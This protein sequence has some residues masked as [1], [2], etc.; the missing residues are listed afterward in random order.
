MHQEVGSEAL[1]VTGQSEGPGSLGQAPGNGDF[2][3]L[4][5][6]PS[7]GTPDHKAHTLAR[8]RAR[9]RG[10]P[11]R[12]LLAVPGLAQPFPSSVCTSKAVDVALWYSLTILR[13][14]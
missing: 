5:D 14:L 2:E 11:H 6:S 7:L 12:A 9:Q 8:A 13:L 10:T 3:L 1:A 4:G